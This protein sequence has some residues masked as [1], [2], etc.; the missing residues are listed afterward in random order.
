MKLAFFFL[1]CFIGSNSGA[2]QVGDAKGDGRQGPQA[3]RAHRG[4]G[5]GIPQ[6]E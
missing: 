6:G 3:E 2:A 1:F 4:A 5:R